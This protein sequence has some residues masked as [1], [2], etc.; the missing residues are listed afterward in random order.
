MEENKKII[1]IKGVAYSM[2]FDEC[3]EKFKACRE[4]MYHRYRRAKLEK[5]DLRQEIDVAFYK[6][7]VAFDVKRKL[8][9][10]TILYPIIE[11]HMI[12]IYRDIN[13]DI[14]KINYNT[15]SLNETVKKNNSTKPIEI[16]DLITA[17]NNLEEVIN[18]R[19]SVNKLNIKEKNV[20][21]LQV[22]G[23]SQTEIA[24]RLNCSQVNV[25]R[26]KRAALSKLKEVC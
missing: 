14:R 18:I 1:T 11:N 5:E 21:I 16:I 9:F 2:T 20:I 25:S 15:L 6:A 17:K 13:L 23:Y 8:E 10:I 22:Q 3:Y 24:K 26:I 4:G 7:F 12:R 19:N